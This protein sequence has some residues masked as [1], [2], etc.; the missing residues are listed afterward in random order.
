MTPPIVCWKVNGDKVFATVGCWS[1]F[2]ENPV[3]A[4]VP[5]CVIVAV[6]IP[7]CVVAVI[8]LKSIVDAAVV[9]TIAFAEFEPMLFKEVVGFVVPEVPTATPFKNHW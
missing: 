4:V 2:K 7:A 6:Q 1:K 3:V 8:F 9:V 5:I